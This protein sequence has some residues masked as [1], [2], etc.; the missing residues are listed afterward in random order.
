MTSNAGANR[1]VDPKHLG[2]DSC[3]NTGINIPHQLWNAETNGGG[4]R[5]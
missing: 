5:L 1:I 3:R 4:N 2:F